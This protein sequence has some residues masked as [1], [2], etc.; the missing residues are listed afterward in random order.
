MVLI[1][2]VINW[3]IYFDADRSAVFSDYFLTIIN[4]VA[5]VDRI[6]KYTVATIPFTSATLDCDP[7][8]SFSSFPCFHSVGSFAERTAVNRTSAQHPQRMG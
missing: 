7:T 3:A 2:G 1:D 6:G 5:A 8:S 4:A